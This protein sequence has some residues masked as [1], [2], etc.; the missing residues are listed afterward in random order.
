MMTG[1]DLDKSAEPAANDGFF[2]L[3]DQLASMGEEDA[4]RFANAFVVANCG[5][6]DAAYLQAVI[7]AGADA[8]EVTRDHA[9]GGSPIAQGVYGTALLHGQHIDQDRSSG[10]FWLRRAHNGGHTKASIILA[11]A[12]WSGENVRR[13]PVVAAEY[14]AH[15]AERGDPVGQ[16][17]LGVMLIEGDG[18]TADEDAG[19][20]WLRRA[21]AA[22]N[23]RAEALLRD[24][25]LPLADD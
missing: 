11:G 15:A 4:L 21:A 2:R 6:L 25:D 24:N 20:G 23:E 18:I 10:L 5:P 14:A 13:D 7:G 9:V 1:S 3:R 8:P 19:I 17:L 16:Y 22:G 12:Y